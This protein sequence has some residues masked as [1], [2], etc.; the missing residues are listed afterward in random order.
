M[1]VTNFSGT[2]QFVGAD[3]IRISAPLFE[4][5]CTVLIINLRYLLMSLSLSQKIEP[6]VPTWQR[7][8]I[9]FGVTDEIFAMSV[10]KIQP[11]T[12]VYMLGM[13]AVAYFGW[14]GG[15][16]LGVVSATLLPE[17]I[18]SALAIAIY[19]MFIAIIVPA[20]RESSPVLKVILIAVLISC[21]FFFVPVLRELGSGWVI[22]ICGV[23]SSAVGAMLFPVKEEGDTG[24]G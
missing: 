5:A 14:I 15:T 10:R 12:T 9:G 23:A 21:L 11:L 1:S 3:L 17:F 6:N 19:A 7:L 24:C 8:I 4:I 2:G 13:I 20:A 16:I 22:I 18:L